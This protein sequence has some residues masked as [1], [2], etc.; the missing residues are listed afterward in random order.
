MNLNH[1]NWSGK[2]YRTAREAFKED[3]HQPEYREP[4]FGW[5][6]ILLS[7][8]LILVALGGFI[9]RNAHA[10]QPVDYADRASNKTIVVERHG[11][12]RTEYN[13]NGGVQ[14]QDRMPD[15]TRRYDRH[16]EDQQHSQR[17]HEKRSRK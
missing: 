13:S 12:T 1:P 16:K 7:V 4:R 8:L 5:I 2:A 11:S 6:G 14:V 17:K 9:P 3:F 10:R 15:Y